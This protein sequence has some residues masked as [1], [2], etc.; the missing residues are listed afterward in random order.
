MVNIRA[1]TVKDIPRILELYQ[2]LSFDPGDYQKAPLEACRRVLEKMKRVS[3]Y[4]LLVAEANGE[5]VGT[6]V[7]VVLPGFARWT[8]S[9]AVV[10]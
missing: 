2:Q 10:E 8:S 5:V 6:T 9:F 4:K 1:A 3:G 7:L